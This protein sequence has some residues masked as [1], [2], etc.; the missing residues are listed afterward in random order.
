MVCPL[1]FTGN[2][3][4]MEASYKIKYTVCLA[5]LVGNV[6]KLM[7]KRYKTCIFI[8]W[9][10]P[11]QFNLQL[12]CFWL[13]IINKAFEC[14]LWEKKIIL[15]IIKSWRLFDLASK[16]LNIASLILGGVPADLSSSLCRAVEDLHSAGGGH[17]RQGDT[18]QPAHYRPRWLPPG[19]CQ[20]AVHC[21]DGGKPALH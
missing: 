19:G 1:S 8:S 21:Q 4:K 15:T 10:Y 5:D 17:L 16:W 2:T 9:K 11:V 20:T 6:F 13:L 7:N 18:G 3:M 14:S 12:E